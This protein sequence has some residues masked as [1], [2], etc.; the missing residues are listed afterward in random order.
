MEPA[1]KKL[2]GGPLAGKVVRSDEPFIVIEDACFLEG[3]GVY[4]RN[5]EGEYVYDQRQSRRYERFWFSKLNP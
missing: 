1:E 3:F 4:V 2:I 5:A